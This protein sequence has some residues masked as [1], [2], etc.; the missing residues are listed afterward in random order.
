M[1]TSPGPGFESYLRLT[2]Y[3]DGVSCLPGPL[4]LP[5]LVAAAGAG[6]LNLEVRAFPWGYLGGPCGLWGSPEGT[7]AS[8]GQRQHRCGDRLLGQLVPADRP[9]GVPGTRWEGTSRWRPAHVS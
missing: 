5:I 4:C 1:G 2:Q 8:P 7:S 9:S 3:M 6:G